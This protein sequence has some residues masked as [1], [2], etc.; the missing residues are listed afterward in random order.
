M[1]G[2][3]GVHNKI[4]LTSREIFCCQASHAKIRIFAVCSDLAPSRKTSAVIKETFAFSHLGL[5][6]YPGR[7][8]KAPAALWTGGEPYFYL[9][10]SAKSLLKCNLKVKT[11]NRGS[12]ICWFFFL[13][14]FISKTLNSLLV[15][16]GWCF[17][18][19][20]PPF[21]FTP[22]SNVKILRKNLLNL[23]VGGTSHVAKHSFKA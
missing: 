16:Q 14:K 3:F 13:P 6:T 11:V 22:C 1:E 10:V 21:P 17:F 4:I 12:K 9:S 7:G 15:K 23:N 2:G 18:L 8:N 20:L 19:P 5:I